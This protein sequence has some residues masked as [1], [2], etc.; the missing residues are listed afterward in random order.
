[1]PLGGLCANQSYLKSLAKLLR[2]LVLLHCL[3]K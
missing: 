1:M 2:L 3:M